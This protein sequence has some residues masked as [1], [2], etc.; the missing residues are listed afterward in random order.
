ML[1]I[2]RTIP[3]GLSLYTDETSNIESSIPIRVV[4]RF[5][6]KQYMTNFKLP[7]PSFLFIAV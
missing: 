3:Y 5:E 4:T 1:D 7:I 6:S 2:Y